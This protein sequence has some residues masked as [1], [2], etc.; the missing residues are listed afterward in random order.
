MKKGRRKDH[1]WQFV[2]YKGDAAV[3]AKCSCGFRYGCYKKDV[4]NPLIIISNPN[5]LYPYCPLCGARKTKYIEE[6]VRINKYS[7]E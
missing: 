2:K 4:L 5:K 3:Y 1:L 6:I 7:W